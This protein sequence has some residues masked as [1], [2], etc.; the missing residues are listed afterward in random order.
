MPDLLSYILEQ[1]Q[2]EDAQ[3][4][5]LGMSEPLQPEELIRSLM[6]STSRRGLDIPPSTWQNLFQ[7]AASQ[8]IGRRKLFTPEGDLLSQRVPFFAPGL[9][10]S[11]AEIQKQIE[12]ANLPP[13]TNRLLQQLEI[14]KA[15]KAGEW[16]PPAELQQKVLIKKKDGSYTYQ[17]MS[18]GENLKLE[19]GDEVISPREGGAASDSQTQR[20]YLGI[21]NRAQSQAALETKLKY[22]TSSFTFNSFTGEMTI[23]QNTPPEALTYFQDTFKKKGKA[24]A[25]GLP[26][27]QSLFNQAFPEETAKPVAGGRV[28]MGDAEKQLTSL[29]FTEGQDPDVI[30]YIQRER[31]KNVPDEQIVTKLQAMG[32]IK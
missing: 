14:K 23:G 16:R 31:G 30:Q 20:T 26:E 6:E 22:P 4:Q 8:D 9:P 32:V 27:V 11:G 5:L 7:S 19:K 17:T 13:S 10:T 15:I 12:A 18:P 24:M 1:K 2:A 3:K 25:K 21:L 28:E 29:L